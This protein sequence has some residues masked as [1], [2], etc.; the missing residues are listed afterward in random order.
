MMSLI[1]FSNF[2]EVY[3]TLLVLETTSVACS[4]IYL[5]NVTLN[6]VTKAFLFCSSVHVSL[7]TSKYTS[8]S[9]SLN[10][11]HYWF[12][13]SVFWFSSICIG[14]WYFLP[15]TKWTFKKDVA[16][17][18]VSYG[19]SWPKN[20]M[21]VLIWYSLSTFLGYYA[22][23]FLIFFISPMVCFWSSL[24]STSFEMFLCWSTHSRASE[25]LNVIE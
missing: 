19:T 23:I 13:A 15:Y 10:V 24:D 18:Y 8:S 6:Y 17:Q 20:V 25:T 1:A 7:H 14:G 16:M 22:H 9:E 4:F 3:L 5:F 11:L 21:N 12:S 2:G